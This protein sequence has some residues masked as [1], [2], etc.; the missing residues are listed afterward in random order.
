MVNLVVHKLTKA[1]SHSDTTPLQL[2]RPW[3][4]G[5]KRKMIA[6]RKKSH[7][8]KRPEISRN[9]SAHREVESAIILTL[10]PISRKYSAIVI[11]GYKKKCT[12]SFCQIQKTSVDSF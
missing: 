5:K 6:G 3:D 1:L 10:Y 12:S 2:S 4:T 11:P 9:A 7:H 8:T